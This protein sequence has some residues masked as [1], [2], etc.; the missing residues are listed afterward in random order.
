MADTKW[1]DPV[2]GWTIADWTTLTLNVKIDHVWN[3]LKGAGDELQAF[4]ELAHS[5]GFDADN[6]FPDFSD[7]MSKFISGADTPNNAV[8]IQNAVW[9]TSQS[10]TEVL[11]TDTIA[12]INTAVTTSVIPDRVTLSSAL[13]DIFS[14]S[15]GTL[16]HM[17]DTDSGTKNAKLFWSWVVQWYQVMNY[18]FYYE[19][20]LEKPV[21]FSAFDTIE[22]QFIEVRTSYTYD[23]GAPAATVFT[24]EVKAPRLNSFFSDIYTAGD[25][26]ETPPFNTPQEVWDYTFGQ[27][28]AEKLTQGWVSV[29]NIA[30]IPVPGMRQAALMDL[31]VGSVDV[32]MQA[33]VREFYRIRFKPKDS[34]RAASPDKFVSKILQYFYLSDD[35]I[36]TFNNFGSGIGKE[37]TQLPEI[38]EQGDGYY[39]FNL[40]GADYSAFTVPSLPPT[41]SSVEGNNMLVLKGDGSLGDAVARVLYTP[42]QDDGTAFEYY[43]P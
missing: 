14:Y 41:S 42:N 9:P 16:L 39:Y 5:T 26:N 20:L 35:G 40:E 12:A 43:T 13:T 6:T 37:L 15:S 36:T 4:N 7:L 11:K 22:Y 33:N 23:N 19:R 2:D 3:T 10:N 18:P 25:L 34:F 17:I 38:T 1:L 31:T 29:D 8:K 30:D 21:N 28:N 27:L 24:C 32:D